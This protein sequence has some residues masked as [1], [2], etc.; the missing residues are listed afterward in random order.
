MVGRCPRVTKMKYASICI[1]LAVAPPA[2]SA[3]T[4]KA[5]QFDTNRRVSY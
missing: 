1:A 5:D 4:A 3:Y 2:M